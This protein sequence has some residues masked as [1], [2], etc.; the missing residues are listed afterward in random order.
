MCSLGGKTFYAEH[1]LKI[2]QDNF[3]A[4]IRKR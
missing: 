1:L 3:I 4:N 2:S